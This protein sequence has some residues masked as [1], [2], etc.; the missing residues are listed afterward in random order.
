MSQNMPVFVKIK[1]YNAVLAHVEELKRKAQRAEQLLEEISELKN[2]EDVEIQS[3]QLTVKEL[4][5]KID[6]F[7]D[8]LLQPAKQ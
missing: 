3:W 1:E 8:V 2:Q 6:L 4:Q 7:D 5:K